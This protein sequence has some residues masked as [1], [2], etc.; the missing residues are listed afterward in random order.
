M[1]LNLNFRSTM[2]TL[3]S[4]CKFNTGNPK[5]CALI[6]ALIVICNVGEGK[7]PP[8]PSRFL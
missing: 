4:V 7:I 1:Q 6:I 8:I 3:F 2:N 5:Y